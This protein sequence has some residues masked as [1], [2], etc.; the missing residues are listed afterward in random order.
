MKRKTQTTGEFA[1]R[2]T[3]RRRALRQRLRGVESLEPRLLMAVSIGDYVWNDLDFDGIQNEAASEGVND[4]VVRLFTSAGTQVGVSTQTANDSLG[5]P[6]YYSFNDVAAGEYYVLFVAPTGRAF[7]TPLQGGNTNTD[8]NADKDGKSSPFTLAAGEMN[9]SIDAGLVATAS[10]GTFVWWDENADGLQ[11][12]LEGGIEGATVRLLKN[13]SQIAVQT[14]DEFGQYF[15]ENLAPG[16][17]AIQFDRPLGFE[18]A[19]P[20]DV[21]SNVPGRNNKDDSDGL[22]TTLI[23]ADFTLAPGQVR[24]TDNKKVPANPQ[25]GDCRLDAKS[26]G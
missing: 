13:G 19:S 8:S 17:Y 26:C 10:V 21:P 18:I 24:Q 3:I 9:V 12:D 4:V 14:T 25:H 6:G 22:G 16:T 20:P 5:N 2:P 7:T 15:F 11:V 1:T 23:T